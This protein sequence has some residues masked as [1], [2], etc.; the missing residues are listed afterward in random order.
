[1]NATKFI[2][3]CA[4]ALLFGA[5][6]TPRGGAVGSAAIVVLKSGS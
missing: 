3:F 1:M 6:E 5:C 2:A 4:L